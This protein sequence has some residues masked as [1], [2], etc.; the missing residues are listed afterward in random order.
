M[1]DSKYNT[2]SNG[3]NSGNRGLDKKL[4]KMEIDFYNNLYHVDREETI[5]IPSE[6]KHT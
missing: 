1:L 6:D 4:E 2:M 5:V 3:N